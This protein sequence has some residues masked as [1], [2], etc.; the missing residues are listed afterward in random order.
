MAHAPPVT[1]D[2]LHSLGVFR[3]LPPPALGELLGRGSVRRLLPRERLALTSPLDTEDYWFVLDGTIAIALGASSAEVEYLGCL[4]PGAC[5]SD[6]Y[7]SAGSASGPTIDCIAASSATLLG[8]GRPALGELM[9]RH[10]SFGGSSSG[11]AITS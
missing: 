5:F 1:V 10:P 3:T 7:R 11:P 9:Q 6:G 8:V 2:S 4:G